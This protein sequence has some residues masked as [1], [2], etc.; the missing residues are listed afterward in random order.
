MDGTI[1][2]SLLAGA[3][4]F[5]MA[6]LTAAGMVL[7]DMRAQERLGSRVRQ[8]HGEERVSTIKVERRTLRE[9]I[10][11]AVSNIGQ[12]ILSCGVVPAATRGQ[13]ETMLRGAGVRGEQSVGVFFGA[14]ILSMIGFPVLVWV[15][16]HNR[17]MS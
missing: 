9:T 7:R 3:G 1:R 14:K 2:F 17:G 6:M 8:I 16:I 4:L 12:T 5:L 10:G 13:L 15:C 11:T